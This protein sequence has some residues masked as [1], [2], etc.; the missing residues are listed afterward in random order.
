M[1]PL[2][3]CYL[4]VAEGEPD[5]CVERLTFLALLREG[6]GVCCLEVDGGRG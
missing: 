3:F 4:E 6:R 2:F 5:D 1:I